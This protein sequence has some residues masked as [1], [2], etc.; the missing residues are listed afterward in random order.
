MLIELFLTLFETLHVPNA[1]YS[2]TSS[3]YLTHLQKILLSC[4]TKNWCL[5]VLL[6]ATNENEANREWNLLLLELLA[7]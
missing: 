5:A 7:I 3:K 6:G 4:F 1:E 2:N